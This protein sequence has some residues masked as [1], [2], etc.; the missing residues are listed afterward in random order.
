MRYLSWL[1]RA[2]VFFA[3]L[4]FAF[5]NNQAVTLS[6][7]FGW[8]WQTTLVIVLL[9]FFAA[10]MIIGVIAMLFDSWQKRREIARLKRELQVQHKLANLDEAQKSPIQPS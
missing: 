10:G 1:W 4:G 9:T 2:I 8:E 7:F 3:L 5:K 6:Y